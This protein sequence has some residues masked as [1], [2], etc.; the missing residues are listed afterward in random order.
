MDHVVERYCDFTC[1]VH[2]DFYFAYRGKEHR[3]LCRLPKLLFDLLDGLVDGFDLNL[4]FVNLLVGVLL[5]L[6]DKLGQLLC[7][8]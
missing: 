2:L 5:G 8:S 1:R 7:L 3:F 4:N 6:S